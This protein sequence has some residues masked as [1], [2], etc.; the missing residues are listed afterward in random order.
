M[1]AYPRDYSWC[2]EPGGALRLDLAELSRSEAT[3]HS[4]GPIV[5]QQQDREEFV[6][7]DAQQRFRILS[8]IAL[9]E[10]RAADGTAKADN[11]ERARQ[12]HLA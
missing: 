10:Q 3:Q 6:V 5:L 7:I 4:M 8:L 9:L 11:Y 12:V 1:P 2:E